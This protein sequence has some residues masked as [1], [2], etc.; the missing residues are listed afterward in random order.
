MED[1]QTRLINLTDTS[2][3]RLKID[4]IRECLEDFRKYMSNIETFNQALEIDKKHH[5]VYINHKKIMEIIDEF[6]NM[7]KINV[8][9]TPNTIIDGYGNIAV[10][11]NGDPYLTLRLLLMSLRTHNNIVFFSK[12]YYAVNTK[13]VETL[14]MILNKKRYAQKIAIVEFNVIDC[15]IANMQTY[16]NKMIFIGDKRDYVQMKKKF[17]IP[18]VYA[19]FGNVDVFI[20]NKGFKDLLLE[21]NE[22]SKENNIKV[23]YYDDT[24]IEDT[25]TFLNRFELTDCFVLLSKNTDLIY[26]FISEIKAKNVY[27]N[28]DPLE[29]YKLS[30]SEKDLIYTKNI[31]MG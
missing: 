12:K 4:I 2:N 25:L 1:L 11:Y 6:I 9:Y 29:D 10:S 21:I 8:K 20:E 19:G 23:N 26:K 3:Y 15:I 30:I 22:F 7:D 24:Q 13:I 28:K 18:T 31:K 14:N 16:F 5:S 17:V 27:I